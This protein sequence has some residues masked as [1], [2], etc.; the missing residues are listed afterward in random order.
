MELGKNKMLAG[1]FSLALAVL[2]G[3]GIFS[4]L[5]ILDLVQFNNLMAKSRQV[6]KKLDAL[7]NSLVDMQAVQARYII[8]GEKR[9]LM[10]YG[11]DPDK[12]SLLLKDIKGLTT[13]QP[14]IQALLAA[15]EPLITQQ[16]ALLHK[17][18]ALMESGDQEAAVQS[19]KSGVGVKNITYIQSSIAAIH[20]VED[21]I[22]AHQKV[23]SHADTDR[24]F[25]AVTVGSL[26]SFGILIAVFYFLRREI[27]LRRATE[28]RLRLSEQRLQTFLEHSPAISFIKDEFGRYLYANGIFKQTV[29][30]KPMELVGLTDFDL[31]PNEMAKNFQDEDLLVFS[32]QKP[33]EK[34]V[35]LA[36]PD[37]NLHDFIFYKFPIPNHFGTRIMGGVAVEITERNRLVNQLHQAQKLEAIGKLA[38]GVAHDFN[39]LLTI[40]I[41]CGEMMLKEL[42]Q[43]NQLRLYAQEIAKAAESAAALTQQLLT[44]SRKQ[45]VQ[46][47]PLNLNDVVTAL[48][49]MLQTLLT[50]EIHLNMF[51]DPDL[52][53]VR[54]DPSQ[55]EQIIMNL[56]SNARDAMPQ[57]GQL[58]I[59]TTNVRLDEAYAQRHPKVTPGPH[60]LMMIADTGEGMDPETLEHIFEPFFTTKDVGK[61]TGLGLASVYGIV[62]QN[63]GHIQVYSEPDLGTNFEI[64]LPQ[65]NVVSEPLGLEAAPIELPRGQETILVVDDDENLC[66]LIRRALQTWGYTVLEARN[67]RQALSVNAQY[68]G[69][70]HLLLV[71]VILPH[72]KGPDLAAQFRYS[73]PDLK[74][75]Y[76]SGYA[77]EALIHQGVVDSGVDFIQKPFKVVSLIKKVRE[78]LDSTKTI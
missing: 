46:P 39:N 25:Y 62:R 55:I 2:A 52:G 49:G 27:A 66:A 61:G 28:E 3:I 47:K 54:A 35:S 12:I 8:T 69:K 40:I 43:D 74:V 63:G 41:G 14:Q 10:A 64:Y 75:L 60:V 42:C 20:R 70:I 29:L 22:L 58:T 67:G 18:T 34:S 44:F 77:D 30:Q 76:M 78:V 15:L 73:N 45:I 71:D 72:M 33:I 6:I 57:G 1:F 37:G 68:P 7:Q 13:G 65:L 48:K 32:E 21:R 4:Y 9:F 23:L 31:W 24:I 5:H 38:A 16:L 56:A 36:D 11:Q 19:L 51:L 53:M 59:K 50:E 26:L 17:R